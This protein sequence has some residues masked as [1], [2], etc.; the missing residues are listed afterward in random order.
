MAVAPFSSMIILWTR[1]LKK[2]SGNRPKRQFA[3][4]LIRLLPSIRLSDLFSLESFAASGSEF[5][6]WQ[7]FADWKG[8]E[9]ERPAIPAAL[10][11]EVAWR[12]GLSQ[13]WTLAWSSRNVEQLVWFFGEGASYEDVTFSRKARGR[14]EMRMLFSELFHTSD[15]SLKIVS[16]HK[17]G[18]R[19]VGCN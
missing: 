9:Q 11:A 5:I 19:E 12:D 6:V 4:R 1:I 16:S 3:T 13:L 14:A 10:M 2:V 7:T 18:S 8:C 15:L 17:D